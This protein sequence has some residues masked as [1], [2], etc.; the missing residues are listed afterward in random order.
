MQ[1][2]RQVI[3]L[4]LDGIQ[5]S[6]HAYSRFSARVPAGTTADDLVDPEFY[7]HVIPKLKMGDEIR[8][9]PTDF[10]FRAEVIV[11]Y[12]DGKRVRLRLISFIELDD[13]TRELDTMHRKNYELKMRGQQKWCVQRL[14]DGEFIKELIPTQQEAINWLED[15]LK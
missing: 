6:E 8:A 11:S 7:V 5:L 15:Y 10:A 14:S 1:D 13:T 4:K 3:P 12:T 2:Q 9:I